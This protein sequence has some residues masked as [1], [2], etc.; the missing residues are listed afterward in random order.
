M[1]VSGNLLSSKTTDYT[2]WDYVE[3]NAAGK[4]GGAKIELDT[5]PDDQV[6][7]DKP[8]TIVD[9][10]G[11]IALSS[12]RVTIT[13]VQPG[14]SDISIRTLSAGQY[15]QD[16]RNNKQ[17][18]AISSW[19]ADGSETWDGMT[20]ERDALGFRYHS[21][22]G[23]AVA[24]GRSE[25]TGETIATLSEDYAA[26]HPDRSSAET[27]SLL[28]LFES[29]STTASSAKENDAGPSVSLKA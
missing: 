13:D 11:V 24:A 25:G 28:V 23:E 20:A 19:S 18:G 3:T 26:T 29:T 6:S 17:D 7:S 14:G 16:L 4:T 9:I 1:L 8:A 21:A 10:G 15:L 22:S 2:D 5:D 12:D 27:A